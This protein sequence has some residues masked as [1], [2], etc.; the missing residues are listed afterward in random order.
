MHCHHKIPANKVY[1]CASPEL[2]WLIVDEIIQNRSVEI[3]EGPGCG[4][5]M[6]DSVIIL[7]ELGNSVFI[8]VLQVGDFE[9]DRLLAD[10]LS[11]REVMF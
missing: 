8:V 5:L 4:S 9:F 3:D 7:V 10:V 2:I 6:Y 1:L 11:L